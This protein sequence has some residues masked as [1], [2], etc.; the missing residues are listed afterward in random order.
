MT[1]H[2]CHRSVAIKFGENYPVVLLSRKP[3]SFEDAVNQINQA[4]GKAI[5]IVADSTDPQALASA[6]DTISKELPGLQLAA[7]VYN[8]RPGIRQVGGFGPF[9]ERTLEQLDTVLAGEVYVD[10][11]TNLRSLIL[12]NGSS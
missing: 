10:R 3:E 2:L 5:G 11:K 4:G 7:A 9:L 12:Q 6:F 1:T 8:V